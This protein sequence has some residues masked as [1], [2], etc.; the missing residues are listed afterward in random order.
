MHFKAFGEVEL[1]YMEL[2]LAG[3]DSSEILNTLGHGDF[4]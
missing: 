1:H 3:R 2:F 4:R